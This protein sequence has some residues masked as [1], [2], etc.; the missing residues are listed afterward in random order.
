MGLLR[1][2]DIYP[3][4]TYDGFELA[5][6]QLDFQRAQRQAQALRR[7]LHDGQ[8]LVREVGAVFGQQLVAGVDEA[9]RWRLAGPRCLRRVE[10]RV[11]DLVEVEF[12]LEAAAQ[13]VPG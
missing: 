9:H 13:C 5:R 12:D 11:V 3:L 7:V 2:A 1:R 6:A 8:R 10:P 4:N